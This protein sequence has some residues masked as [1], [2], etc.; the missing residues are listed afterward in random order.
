MNT[1]RKTWGLIKEINNTELT[2]TRE[3]TVKNR[4]CM[5]YRKHDDISRLWLVAEGSLNVVID[6]KPLVL[7]QFNMIVIPKGSWYTG[8]VLP[9]QQRVKIIETCF[10]NDGVFEFEKTETKKPPE[11]VPLRRG[12]N[13]I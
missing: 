4:G 7:S 12:Y 6:D 11:F 3:I 2:V 10:N 1:T 9:D 5:S 8:Y 13:G